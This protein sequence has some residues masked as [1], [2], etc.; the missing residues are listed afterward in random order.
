MEATQSKLAKRKAKQTDV[1]PL[2][3]EM[4]AQSKR[5][6][7]DMQVI[8]LYLPGAT[9]GA[10]S[11]GRFGKGPYSALPFRKLN[12]QCRYVECEAVRFAEELA[13]GN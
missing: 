6:L 1:V 11:M 4:A 10:L 3:W 9:R 2:P 8:Q 7:T 12:R 13:G 5:M